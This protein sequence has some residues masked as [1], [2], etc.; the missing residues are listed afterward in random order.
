[1]YPKY[2][3]LDMTQRIHL[4][5]ESFGL[6]IRFWIKNPDLD[7]SK[8][9]TLTVCFFSQKG[10]LELEIRNVRMAVQYNNIIR[11]DYLN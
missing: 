4:H 7:F 10:S 3:V 2:P 8:E 9:Q 1:M 6:I 11:F 5:C